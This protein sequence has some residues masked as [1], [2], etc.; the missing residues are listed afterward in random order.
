VRCR[1]LGPHG[2]PA[3]AE[4]DVAA[5][6]ACL[7]G[8]RL[9]FLGKEDDGSTTSLHEVAG[10][11]VPSALAVGVPVVELS[12]LLQIEDVA[13]VGDKNDQDDLPLPCLL[14]DDDAGI[15]LARRH[16][17]DVLLSLETL[18]TLLVRPAQGGS[19][20]LVPATVL[21]TSTGVATTKEGSGLCILDDPVPRPTNPRTCMAAGLEGPVRHALLAG[22]TLGPFAAAPGP[23]APAVQVAYV[24]LTLG[25][26][27]Q[28]SGRPP[29]RLLVRI[30]NDLYDT[31]GRPVRRRIATDYFRNGS[32]A[33]EEECTDM[34]RVAWLV[35]ALLQPGARVLSCRVDVPRGRLVRTDVRGV[36]EASLDAEMD[37]LAHWQAAGVVLATTA[38]LLPGEYLLASDRADTQGWAGVLG[39]EDYKGRSAS[40]PP[41][42]VW[43]HAALMSGHPMTGNKGEDDGD[44]KTASIIDLEKVLVE[45]ENVYMNERALQEC[46]RMWEWQDDTS[47]ERIPYTFKPKQTKSK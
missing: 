44:T 34:D 6:P 15:Y 46:Y 12:H 30:I 45:A 40:Q 39:E 36:A 11:T 14:T 28:R 8:T 9:M 13:L 22:R 47:T 25:T 5:Y 35:E 31:S 21:P 17:A 19:R 32:P 18:L 16:G 1:G 23:S 43:V 4:F 10:E 42:D 24:L 7:V 41:F 26:V 3:S 33:A 27:A 29:L 38:G 2:A 20:W 37:L